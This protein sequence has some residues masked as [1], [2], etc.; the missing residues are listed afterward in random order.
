MRKAGAG[1]AMGLIG[2]VYLNR[3]LEDRLFAV[4]ALDLRIYLAASALSIAVDV[5]GYSRSSP[6]LFAISPGSHARGSP[7]IS[8]GHFLPSS[9]HLA[10]S[11]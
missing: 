6:R 7:W 1:I 3:F 4:V 2:S 8:S 5:G 10:L 9:L 11:G